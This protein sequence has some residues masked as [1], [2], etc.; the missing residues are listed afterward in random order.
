M[1]L[2]RRRSP[3]LYPNLL[4]QTWQVDDGVNKCDARAQIVLK[5]KFNPPKTFKFDHYLN[6]HVIGMSAEVSSSINISGA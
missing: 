1:W 4:Q 2:Q 5:D 3:F 6:P